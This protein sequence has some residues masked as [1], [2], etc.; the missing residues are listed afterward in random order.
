MFVP[1]VH[2]NSKKR[3]VFEFIILT[4]KPFSKSKKLLKHFKNILKFT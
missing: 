3:E 1:L 2:I 4:S